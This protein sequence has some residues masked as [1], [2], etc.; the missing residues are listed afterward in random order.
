MVFQDKEHS[1]TINELFVSVKIVKGQ[2]EYQQHRETFNMRGFPTV[3]VLAPD[4]TE[5]DRIVGFSNDAE[6]FM[7]KLV[8]YAHNRNTLSKLLQ[9]YKQDSMSIE[10]T[11][12]LAEKYMNRFEAAK[13]QPYFESVLRLTQAGDHNRLAREARYNIALYET[14]YERNYQP[15]LDL[16]PELQSK[17]RK[18]DAY[19]ALARAHN[20]QA[21]TQK[22]FFYYEKALEELPD[23]TG[24]MNSFAWTVFEYKYRDKYEQAIRVAE[25]AVDIDPDAASIWDT[26][27]WL[28]YENGDTA[29]AVT[30][31][32]KALNID[33]DSE[34]Y[35]DNLATF[36]GQIE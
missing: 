15:L 21:D 16:L 25:Q 5:R 4:G 6:T 11:Y 29:K 12:N 27:G 1:Q 31:M 7:Q 10:N 24:L 32:Q 13:A 3:I 19:V 9:I 26:L 18:R 14:Q 28:Y 20:T 33:P 35:R 23:D 17:D 22:T 30:A 36:K 2:G 8:D 34:Y